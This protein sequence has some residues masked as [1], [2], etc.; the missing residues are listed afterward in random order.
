MAL[1]RRKRITK[2]R[3]SVI[4][5]TRVTIGPEAKVQI[6][7]LEWLKLFHPEAR[8]HVIK[9]DN[10]GR[11]S[12][13]G[14]QLSIAQGLHSG[15]SDIFLAWPTTRYAGLWLEIKKE[16]WKMV[17]SNQEHTE[18]QLLFLNKMIKRGYHGA[19]GVGIDSCIDIVKSYLDT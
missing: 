6:A 10:E 8:E 14:L 2:R 18:R 16:K 11:R 7:L 4:K 13:V 3:G 1:I 17:P 5:R 15:A 19:M 9:L 12:L